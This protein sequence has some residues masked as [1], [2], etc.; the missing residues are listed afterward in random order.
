M[1]LRI[2]LFILL[3]LCG[4]SS[5]RQRFY[6]DMQDNYE[7]QCDKYFSIYAS[8]RTKAEKA[9]EDTI[10]LSLAERDKA[11]FYWR[12][13]L[14]IAGSEARLAVM[15]EKEGRE[16]DAQHLFASASVYMALQKKMLRDHLWEMPHTRFA[17]SA[18]NPADVPT[19]DEWRKR[20]AALDLANHVRW[21]STNA[22]SEPARAAS[23]NS[24]AQ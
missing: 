19:P 20:I 23:T 3:L 7:V 18:T 11:K 2:S 1:N 16:E 24:S 10:E 6:R 21:K 14:M 9:M 17:E 22:V 13:N 8:D 4:C 15:A 12:F 5:R